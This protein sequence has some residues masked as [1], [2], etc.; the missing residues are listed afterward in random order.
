M[1]LNTADVEG[2]CPFCRIVRG[3][4]PSVQILCEDRNWIAFFPLT[5]AT[6]GHTL[7][8]PRE[9][10]DD[11]W[12]LTPSLGADLMNGVVRVGRAIRSAVT[13]AGMNLISSSGAAA[14]QTVFHLHLHVVPRYEGDEINPIWP[15]KTDLDEDLKERIA[16]G[17][18]LACA[19]H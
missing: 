8:I 1:T 14:E 12:S 6:P 2:S 15:Q 9:H 7:V 5:P 19:T 13:P 17:I 3:D 4:D 10:V 16:H 18:R 11:L